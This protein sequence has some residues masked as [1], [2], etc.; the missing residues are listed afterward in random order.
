MAERYAIPFTSRM[1]FASGLASGPSA[2][3]SSRLTCPFAFAYTF[4]F[5]FGSPG[6]EGPGGGGLPSARG[7]PCA[8]A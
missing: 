3:S 6:G 8:F 2:P 4:S 1:R 5:P 7:C